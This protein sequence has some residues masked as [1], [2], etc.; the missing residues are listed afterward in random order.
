MYSLSTKKVKFGAQYYENKFFLHEQKF[1][2]S[3]MHKERCS[4]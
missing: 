4:S 2:S 1:C 3:Q